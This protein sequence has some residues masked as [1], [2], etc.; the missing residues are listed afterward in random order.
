MSC[1]LLF[2]I[3]TATPMNLSFS[4]VF[5]SPPRS[6]VVP[7]SGLETVNWKVSSLGEVSSA[8]G[9]SVGLSTGWS[10]SIS[11]G[12]SEVGVLG[13]SEGSSL[14]GGS[15]IELGGDVGSSPPSFP[16]R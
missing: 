9:P 13:S 6:S 16:T 15:T 2:T 8:E 10:V 5:V 14:G 7:S 12:A 1:E 3:V 11:V 4:G